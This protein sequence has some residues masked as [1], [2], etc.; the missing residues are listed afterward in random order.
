VRAA[1]GAEAAIRIDDPLNLAHGGDNDFIVVATSD[2]GLE[3]V[4]EVV[5]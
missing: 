2:D 3:V 5:L 1:L 4:V